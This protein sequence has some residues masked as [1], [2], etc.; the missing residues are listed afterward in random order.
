MV[1][2][3]S[4]MDN[5]TV[6]FESPGPLVPFAVRRDKVPTTRGVKE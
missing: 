1:E 5:M 6:S 2:E 3:L 4:R